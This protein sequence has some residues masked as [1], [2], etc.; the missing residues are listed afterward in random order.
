M[1]AAGSIALADN[2]P[3]NVVTFT[4]SNSSWATM[5]D[6]SLPGPVTAI[7]VNDGNISSV[8]AAGRYVFPMLRM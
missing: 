1:V 6:G 3:A 2:T 8:F 4:S 7:A 5:G